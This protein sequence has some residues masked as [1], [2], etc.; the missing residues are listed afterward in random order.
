MRIVLALLGF[1]L[2]AATPL[3]GPGVSP[4]LSSQGVDAMPSGP[5]S[6]GGGVILL[7][8]GT[9]LLTGGTNLLKE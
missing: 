9:N 6:T 1:L 4:T 3:S 7:T 5:V 2:M 8:G